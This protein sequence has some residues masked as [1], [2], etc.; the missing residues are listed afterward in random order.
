[1][2]RISTLI[3]L[4]VTLLLAACGSHVIRM[5][6]LAPAQVPS[7]SS[8]Y[9]HADIRVE[10]PKGIEDTM[11]TRIYYTRSDLTRSYYLY[12]QWSQ[13]LNRLVM[14]HLIE[15]LQKS[16]TFRNVLD[17]ASEAGADYLLETTI[18][19]F[20]QRITDRGAYADISIGLRLLRNG[21]HRLVKSRRFDYRIPCESTDAAGFVKAANQAMKRL[22]TDMVQ[23]L[24]Q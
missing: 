1:M 10:Y 24:R 5:Y 23:W 21:D 7:G 9:R 18:Y 14:A 8:P 20:D 2:K 13:P 22:A 19:R 11:G 3:I 6:T 17:Y 16:H 12:N 15:A 4:V